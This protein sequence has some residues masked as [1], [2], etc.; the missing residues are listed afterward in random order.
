MR[1][2][3]DRLLKERQAT[4][5]R[6]R[7]SIERQPFVRPVAISSQ[8]LGETDIKGFSKDMSQHGIAVITTCDWATGTLA[9]LHVHSLFGAHVTVRGEARWTEPYGEGWYI[10]G[11]HFVD[12][13]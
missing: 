11:W 5:L 4:I 3:I 9:T 13:S 7:R 10:T 6:E 2:D 8:R 1:S 12:L